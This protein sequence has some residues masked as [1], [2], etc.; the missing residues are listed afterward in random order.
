MVIIDLEE[1]LL[2]NKIT[3][4]EFGNEGYFFIMG[5]DQYL[6]SNKTNDTVPSI[7]NG[8]ITNNQKTTYFTS[9][10]GVKYILISNETISG[11]KVVG[12]ISINELQKESISV[13]TSIIIFTLLVSVIAVIISF[14]VSSSFAKPI[15]KLMKLM[16]RVEGG[17]L[18]VK[19]N[20]E[21]DDEIGQLIRSFGQMIN[22]LNDLMNK[23]YSDQQ[24][25]RKAQLE[26]LQS[27]INPHFLYNTLDSIVWMARDN[28]SKEVI[29]MVMALTKLLRI[30]LSK[31]QE[32]ISIE[33]E[34]IHVKSYLT[35]QGMRYKDKLNYEINV[36][37]EAYEYK[38]LKLTLQPIVEN[39]IYHGIK[40]SPEPGT[41]KVN[42]EFDDGKII[43]IVEDTGVGMPQEKVE[44]LNEMLVNIGKGSGFGIRNVNERIRIHFG[45]EYGIRV[46]SN[47]GSGTRIFITIPMVRG[48]NYVE[49]INC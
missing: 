34:I 3:K 24:V 43:F 9:Q 27:Q 29:D 44:E 10:E 30:S 11:W 21:Y 41:I 23:I 7:I 40:N 35:I 22:K 13:T 14:G 38:I 17:D 33:D 15:K 31:G 8:K 25:L 32:V 37:R 45:S 46:E 1:K 12:L 49:G 20:S 47:L 42:C 36:P 2:V 19:M 16:K 26:V 18:T 48:E 4:P 39:A 6:V 28:K 5:N